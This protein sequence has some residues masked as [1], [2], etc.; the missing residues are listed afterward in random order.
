MTING[1][2]DE[3]DYKGVWSDH[4]FDGQCAA[5]VT[6]TGRAGCV[7]FNGEPYWK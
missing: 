5:S 6:H 1:V 4:Q 7:I 3:N 2:C